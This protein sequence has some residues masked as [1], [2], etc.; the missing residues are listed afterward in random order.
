MRMRAISASSSRARP[1][2]RAAVEAERAAVLEV[3]RQPSDGSPLAGRQVD[4]PVCRPAH[5]LARP[6]PC[7]GDRGPDRAGLTR[8]DQTGSTQ[9]DASAA[10][11]MTA[12]AD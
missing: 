2:D 5:R 3:L 10:D 7:L 4:R 11:A 6:R 12:S 1:A 8:R 9:P